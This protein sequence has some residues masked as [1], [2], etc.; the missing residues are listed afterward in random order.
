MVLR[1][2]VYSKTSKHVEVLFFVEFSFTELDLVVMRDGALETT[3]S[4]G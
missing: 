2:V 3:S 4:E 1:R